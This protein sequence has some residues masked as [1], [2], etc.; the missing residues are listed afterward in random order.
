MMLFSI[1]TLRNLIKC[2]KEPPP[3]FHKA[4]KQTL[5]YIKE[6]DR[7]EREWAAIWK[8]GRVQDGR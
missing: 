4:M 6:R 3:I 1:C 8:N 5:E 7:M 2:P